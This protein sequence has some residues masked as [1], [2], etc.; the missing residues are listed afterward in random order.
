MSST[1]LITLETSETRTMP[2]SF[3]GPIVV[4]CDV[5]KLLTAGAFT[6][7]GV[8]ATI[9]LADD[10]SDVFADVAGVVLAP[11][12]P[13]PETADASAAGRPLEAVALETAPLSV[14]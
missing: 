12:V 3:A 13:E 4:I 11:A 2:C 5:A 14:A 10:P 7:F 8:P 9:W 6:V 1:L